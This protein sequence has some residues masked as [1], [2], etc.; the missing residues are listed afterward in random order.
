MTKILRRKTDFTSFDQVLSDIENLSSSSYQKAGNWSLGQV[1]NHL[2]GGIDL[3]LGA[4]RLVMKSVIFLF[5]GFMFL[6]RIGGALG[7]RLPTTI[8]QNQPVD[9]AV[10]LEEYRKQLQQL[11]ATNDPSLLK[12]NLWHANHHLS[13]LVPAA[14]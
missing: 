3:S 7:L 14:R 2:A 1:C 6:G 9:D 13:F 11:L 4:P 10:G 5:F 8:P 12:F